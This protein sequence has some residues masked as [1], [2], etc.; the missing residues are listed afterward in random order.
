MEIVDIIND[1]KRECKCK[2]VHETAVRDVRIGQGLV[3]SVGEILKENNFLAKIC[4]VVIDNKK[5]GILPI[6]IHYFLGS[7]LVFP[8]IYG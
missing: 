1:F 7:I 5:I 4:F 6:L 8:P 2:R 3:N